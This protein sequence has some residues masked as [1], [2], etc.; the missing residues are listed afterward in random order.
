MIPRAT[1]SALLTHTPSN[2]SI[3]K[4]TAE[5]AQRN[6]VQFLLFHPIF[7]FYLYD[8]IDIFFQGF[9]EYIW[10]DVCHGGGKR[11]LRRLG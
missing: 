8:G 7:V 9:Y 4:H 6:N 1:P 5:E 11:M 2:Q 10:F 3:Q